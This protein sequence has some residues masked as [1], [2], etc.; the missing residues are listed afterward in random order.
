MPPAPSTSNEPSPRVVPPL[1]RDSSSSSSR[2]SRITF[3]IPLSSP[4]RSPKV[5][6]RSAGPPTPRACS[7][8]LPNSTPS[9]EARAISS[10]V[11]G[12]TS[13]RNPDGASYQV[14]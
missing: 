9:L 2:C 6:A 11:D 8:T 7:T 12:F 10:P 5:I 3:D 13:G 4:A 1:I 14:P